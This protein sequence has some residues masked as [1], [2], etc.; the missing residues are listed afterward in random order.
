MMLKHE[1]INGFIA[2]QC[3]FEHSVLLGAKKR[4]H[5]LAKSVLIK[6]IHTVKNWQIIPVLRRIMDILLLQIFSTL[7]VRV[8]LSASK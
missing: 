1:C 2:P 8:V 6:C 7:Q 3:H 4:H 5:F